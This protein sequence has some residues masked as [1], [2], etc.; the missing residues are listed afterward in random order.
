MILTNLQRKAVRVIQYD[1]ISRVVAAR[2]QVFHRGY[3]V[4]FNSLIALTS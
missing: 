2:E 4:G 1:C 3:A